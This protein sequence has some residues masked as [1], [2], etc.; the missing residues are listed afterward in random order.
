M[1]LDRIWQVIEQESAFG[2]GAVG[3]FRHFKASNLGMM[4]TLVPVIPEP[5]KKFLLVYQPTLSKHYEG[6]RINQ[7]LLVMK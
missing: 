6:S 2:I 4:G 5:V 1:K 3:G 7:T